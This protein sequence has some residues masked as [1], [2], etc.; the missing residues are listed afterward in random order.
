MSAAYD[1]VQHLADLAPVVTAA[2]GGADR[3]SVV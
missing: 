3:K 1:F 2:P